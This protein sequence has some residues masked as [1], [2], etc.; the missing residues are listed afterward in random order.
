LR[1]WKRRT[2][3]TEGGKD[4]SPRPEGGGNFP[5]EKRSG[6]EKGQSRSIL[7][8]AVGKKKKE[9]REKRENN[10]HLFS[11][12]GERLKGEKNSL[13]K[14][15]ENSFTPMRREKGKGLLIF[16]FRGA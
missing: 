5:R 8:L 13:Q 15:G 2:P 9:K 3:F 4:A 12:N 1:R 11:S 16:N 10:R 7:P 14:R 6:Q